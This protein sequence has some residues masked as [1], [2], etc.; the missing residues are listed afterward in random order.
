[1]PRLW[2]LLRQNYD[3][4]LTEAPAVLDHPLSG[5][6]AGFQDEI[7]YVLASPV[8]DRR[9]V[10]AGLEFL[11]DR[12]LAPRALIFNRVN[13]YYLEDVRQQRIIRSLSGEPS[14]PSDDLM[15]FFQRLKLA[16]KQKLKGRSADEPAVEQVASEPASKEKDELPDEEALPDF[17]GEEE[18]EVASELDDVDQLEDKKPEK[19]IDPENISFRNWLGNPGEKQMK[20]PGEG[21]K[22]DEK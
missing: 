5:T 20:K 8:S 11:E 18:A 9:I 4:I 17:I 2:D 15:A 16:V 19:K 7:I 22:D 21:S 14:N 6:I 10:D 13:P 3:I 1:M 12:G